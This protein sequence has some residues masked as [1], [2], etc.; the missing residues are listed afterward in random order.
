MKVESKFNIGDIVY[1]WSI[2]KVEISRGEIQNVYISISKDK[3][4]C[5]YYIVATGKLVGESIPEHL[6]FPKRD[7]VFD[8]CFALTK[9]I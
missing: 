9:D 8:F 4:K 7:D 5:S 2:D 1:F 6:V 3:Q